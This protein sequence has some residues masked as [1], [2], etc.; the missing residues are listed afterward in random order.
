[1][2]SRNFHGIFPFHFDTLPGDKTVAL[3][4]QVDGEATVKWMRRQAWCNGKVGVTGDWVRWVG[5]K[6]GVFGVLVSNMMCLVMK[7]E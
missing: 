2:D 4:E 1:M 3:E 7:E 6:G 5:G